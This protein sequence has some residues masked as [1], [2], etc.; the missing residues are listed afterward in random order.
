MDEIKK[1]NPFLTRGI[2][3][4]VNEAAREDLH[5]LAALGGKQVAIQDTEGSWWKGN[6]TSYSMMWVD[7]DEGRMRIPIGNI[8]EI[9][10]VEEEEEV[11]AAQQQ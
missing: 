5:G 8:V 2:V 11:D 3:D 10:A 6:L 4:E 7:L 9:V 1:K